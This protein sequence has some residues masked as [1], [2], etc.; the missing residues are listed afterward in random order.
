MKDFFPGKHWDV[1]T[2][3]CQCHFVESAL[4]RVLYIA[5]AG[6]CFGAP[7]AEHLGVIFMSVL[8]H[9]LEK[10][11]EIL[12]PSPDVLCD[13]APQKSVLGAYEKHSLKL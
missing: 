13:G 6:E 2:P 1:V 10:I 9:V 8:D 3:F 7:L 4:W 5:V 12:K 11:L